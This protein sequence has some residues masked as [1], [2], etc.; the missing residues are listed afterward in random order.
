M[1]IVS[2]SVLSATR[3]ANLVPV[4]D[5]EHKGSYTKTIRLKTLDVNVP[6]EA[7]GREKPDSPDSSYRLDSLEKQIDDAGG[8]ILTPIGLEAMADGSV[9]VIDGFRRMTV[10]RKKLLDPSTPKE[11][12]EK[13]E[14]MDFTV[15]Y[16]L[17]SEERN[18]ILFNHGS[19]SQL[20]K[21][22]AVKQVW[23]QKGRGLENEAI[24]DR[25]Y[26]VLL[27]LS[28]KDDQDKLQSD[29]TTLGDDAKG[30]R[31][32]LKKF[33]DGKI[34]NYYIDSYGMTEQV[35][36]SVVETVAGRFDKDKSIKDGIQLFKTSQPRLVKLKAAM[37]RDSCE[38]F[39]ADGIGLDS[40]KI[41]YP[42][43]DKAN[44]GKGFSPKTGGFRFN[45]M[46]MTFVKE[47]KG[48]KA[49]EGQKVLT[50]DKL[51]ERKA[52]AVSAPTKLAFAIARGEAIPEGA[53]LLAAD[54]NAA[55]LEDIQKVIMANLDAIR[56]NHK[57]VYDCFQAIAIPDG[58]SA[59]FIVA[60]RKLIG[61]KFT[62]PKSD[63]STYVAPTVAA[64]KEEAQAKEEA[65]KP[66]AKPT[67]SKVKAKAG[68]KNKRK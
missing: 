47:D 29:L 64:Q 55:S 45:E 63:L 54:S 23:R 49:D 21:V 52:L 48:V 66:E 12:R 2:A 62:M 44:D 8:K 59:G 9:D 15:H 3:V 28:S 46:V 25:L 11:V 1:S 56:D 34:G 43:W 7:N 24:Y 42:N 41:P 22:E 50:S 61:E 6:Y 35:R 67:A 53:D 36:M 37:N 19:Q 26:H 31:S 18:Q 51:K 57:G 39:K 4:P 40:K 65:A 33:F 5:T 38:D 20:S 32:R 27:P 68:G 30:R 60:F 16:N 58:K 10:A 17:T 13:L 14:Y